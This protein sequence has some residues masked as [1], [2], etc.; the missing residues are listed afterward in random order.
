MEAHWARRA[1][2]S[3]SLAATIPQPFLGKGCLV[4]FEN[5]IHRRLSKHSKNVQSFRLNFQ[6]QGSFVLGRKQFN[7]E[8]CGRPLRFGIWL[9]KA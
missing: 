4:S 8:V 9:Q 6:A 7:K 1:H 2:G 5:V 3:A